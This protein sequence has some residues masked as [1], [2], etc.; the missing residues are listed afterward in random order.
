[1][2]GILV[3]ISLHFFMVVVAVVFMLIFLVE[4]QRNDHEDYIGMAQSTPLPFLNQ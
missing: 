3:Y 2:V 1:M 4:S